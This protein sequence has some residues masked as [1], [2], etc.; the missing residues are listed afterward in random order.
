M[1]RMS[2]SEI[3]SVS[4][5]RNNQRWVGMAGWRRGGW[6]ETYHLRF[7]CTGKESARCCRYPRYNQVLS[8]CTPSCWPKCVVFCQKHRR[9]RFPPA[10]LLWILQHSRSS[11]SL[12]SVHPKRLR[13]QNHFVL[14]NSLRPYWNERLGRETANLKLTALTLESII[15]LHEALQYL[16]VTICGQPCV[17]IAAGCTPRDVYARPAFKRTSLTSIK[18]MFCPIFVQNH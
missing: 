14:W 13:R 12:P 5:L 4:S 2:L 8:V 9:R 15:K 10:P 3:F 16:V 7:S 11:L 1:P 6:G 17:G 18:V